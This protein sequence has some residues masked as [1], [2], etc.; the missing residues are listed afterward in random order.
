MASPPRRG[1]RW[2]HDGEPHPERAPT[3][4]VLPRRQLRPVA[5]QRLPARH[6]RPLVRRC[7]HRPGPALRRRPGADPGR[8]GRARL[9]R[10]HRP[11]RLR[12][13][14][15]AP[16]RPAGRHPRRA[17][18]APG[19]CRP[20]RPARA[21]RV[22]RDR[23]GL[24][25]RQRQRLVRPAVADPGRRRRLARAGPAQR[26]HAADRLR[27][28]RRPPPPYGT[29]HP[30]PTARPRPRR[31]SRHPAPVRRGHVHRHALLRRAADGERA[32]PDAAA[33]YA[34]SQPGAYRG[35]Q[36][37]TYGGPPASGASR[38]VRWPAHPAGPAAPGRPR[39][40]RR[41]RVAAAPA[42]SSAW[43]RSASPWSGSA[44]ARPWTTRSASRAARPPWASS[45]P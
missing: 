7:L 3:E 39:P 19:R 1:P 16:A 21:R 25:D 29:P 9:P 6:R 8:G 22:P 42:R 17:C 35:P 24:L 36:P 5:Q 20:D 10:R 38:P 37:G 43:C 15:A 11:D 33:P 18:R 30:R 40:R 34:G 28:R 12:H 23:R 45:S 13:P 26:P 31:R 2:S 44:S 14:L 27:Q 41:A 4:H 32:D